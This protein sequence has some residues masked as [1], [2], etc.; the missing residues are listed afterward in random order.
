[1][2]KKKKKKSVATH[3]KE[4]KADDAATQTTDVGYCDT[5]LLVLRPVSLFRQCCRQQQNQR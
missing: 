5:V 1:M 2:I 4:K 3:L